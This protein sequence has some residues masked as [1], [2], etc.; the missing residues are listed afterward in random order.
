MS[1]PT[2]LPLYD[3][4]AADAVLN[5]ESSGNY[6]DPGVFLDEV[7]RVLRPGGHLLWADIRAT[8]RKAEVEELFAN[9]DLDVIEFRDITANV[10]R[11]IDLDQERRNDEISRKVP[12]PLRGFFRDIAAVK[13]TRR[14]ELFVSGQLS[15]FSAHLCK[16]EGS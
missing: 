9:S 5:I 4:S 3:S 7:T 8:P 14:Y 10:I 11:A 13:G 6:V 2:N 12:G 15:Y 1:N 16:Q